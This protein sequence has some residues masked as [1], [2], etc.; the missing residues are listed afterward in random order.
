MRHV[1]VD[2]AGKLNKACGHAKLA[3]LPSEIERVDRDAVAAETRTGIKR[4]VAEWFGTGAAD[5]FPDVD[6][7]S[8]EKLFE[9]V[10]HGD[11][12]AAVDIF[13]DFYGFCCFA[14]V[15]WDHCVDS[16]AVYFKGDVH[17]RF[18]DGT[19]DLWYCASVEVGV[20]GVF[21]F[22]RVGHVE[23]FASFES[24]SFEDWLHDFVGCAGIG[25]AFEDDKLTFAEI[26]GDGAAGLLDVVHVRLAVFGERGWYAEDKGI[27]L[28]ELLHV[29]GGVEAAGSDHFLDMLVRDVLEWRFAGIDA[30]D[31]VRID[32]EAYNGSTAAN[33]LDSERKA[34]IAQADNAY[35]WGS[36]VWFGW[37]DKKVFTCLL[38]KSR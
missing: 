9:L 12:D 25:R 31:G 7:H 21:A 13:D 4:L 19:D 37:H 24:G 26:F 11:I 32:I 28:F 15:D 23:V 34:D 8:V 20:A 33:E 6:A 29:A 2:L 17:G 22:G 10:Y 36:C 5:D 14:G 30:I 3:G 27:R 38:K 1:G 16:V 18:V 35:G